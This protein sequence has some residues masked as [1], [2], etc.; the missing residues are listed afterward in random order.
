MYAQI[1][2]D[3]LALKVLL[4]LHLWQVVEGCSRMLLIQ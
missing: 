4:H 2:H 3:E 1:L